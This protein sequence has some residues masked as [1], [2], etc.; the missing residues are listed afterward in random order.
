[1]GGIPPTNGTQGGIYTRVYLRVVITLQSGY[2]SG[3]VILSPN[4]GIPQGV[5]NSLLNPGIPQGVVNTLLPGY[6]SGCG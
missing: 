1:M 3:C 5:Y 6:T 4:P 2:T